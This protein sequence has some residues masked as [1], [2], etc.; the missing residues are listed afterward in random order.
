MRTWDASR[1]SLFDGQIHAVIIDFGGLLG[2]GTRKVAVD[3][4]TLSFAPA[5]KPGAIV[6]E[7]T[8]NQVDW[9]RNISGVSPS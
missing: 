5:G 9:R 2:I 7:L 3:W 4:R 8:R 1:I 6:L